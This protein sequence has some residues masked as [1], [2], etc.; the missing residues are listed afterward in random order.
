M[1]LPSRP[2]RA[3]E[4]KLASEAVKGYDNMSRPLRARELKLADMASLRYDGVAPLAG[5]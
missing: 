1:E 4:L 3:R 5:A 2:L